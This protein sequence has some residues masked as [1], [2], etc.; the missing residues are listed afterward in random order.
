MFVVTHSTE[1][2][3]GA[4]TSPVASTLVKRSRPEESLPSGSSRGKRPKLDVKPAVATSTAEAEVA[5]PAPLSR[6]D[7][8]PTSPCMASGNESRDSSLDTTHHDVPASGAGAADWLTGGSAT[9]YAVTSRRP[10]KTSCLRPASNASDTFESVEQE[11]CP[12]PAKKR[13]SFDFSSSSCELAGNP[14]PPIPAP[15]SIC[16]FQPALVRPEAL[17]KANLVMMLHELGSEF[18]SENAASLLRLKRRC[19]SVHSDLP[20]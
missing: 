8:D 20:P 9:C 5:S 6:E 4:G 7:L 10:R 14:P 15:A 12:P 16:N 17:T 2:M 3:E 11:E 1:G 19:V 13:V 18:Q